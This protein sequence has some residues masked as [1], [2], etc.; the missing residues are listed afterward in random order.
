MFKLYD[1]LP[2]G[3]CYKVRLLLH[4][5]NI[6]F[7]RVEIN[8]LQ[9]ESR[10]PEFLNLNLNGRVPVL[11]TENGQFI[12]ESNAILFYF[13]TGTKFFPNAKF[14]QAKVMQWLFFEQ[15]SHEPY[16]ATSRYW[17]SI[18]NKGDEYQAALQAKRKPGYA[19]LSVMEQHLTNHSFFV[20]ESYTIADIA[21][22]AYTHV[23]D[24]GGFDLSNFP[25]IQ[26][27]IKRVK[28]QPNY[29]SILQA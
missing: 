12:A 6:S 20:E 13:S 15:Y 25:A 7:A 27:W 3:N 9:G 29:I 23:A 1:F 8:I 26:A 4:Q 22:F 11:E 21:L 16:I 28:S 24:E 18:L 5:L 17:L 2:S 19:A 10:K 14:S